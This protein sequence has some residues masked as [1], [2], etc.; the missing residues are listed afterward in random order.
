VYLQKGLN[1]AGFVTDWVRN[2]G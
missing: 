1:E 2:A